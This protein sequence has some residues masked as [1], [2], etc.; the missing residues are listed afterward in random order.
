[1]SAAKQKTIKNVYDVDNIDYLSP[2]GQ[3]NSMISKSSN[4]LLYL[5][6]EMRYGGGFAQWVVDRMDSVS[7]EDSNMKVRKL[8]I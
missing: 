3:D 8:V 2:K 7:D 5:E 6:L 1:M 4:D